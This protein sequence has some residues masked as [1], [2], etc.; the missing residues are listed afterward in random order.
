MKRDS[1]AHDP[2][3]REALPMPVPGVNYTLKYHSYHRGTVQPCNVNIV[4]LMLLVSLSSTLFSS[5]D[6]THNGILHILN[7]TS[8]FTPHTMAAFTHLD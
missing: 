6:L 3:G 1:R 2:K 8:P 5:Q 4:L 7:P